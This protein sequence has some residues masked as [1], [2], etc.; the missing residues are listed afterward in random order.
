MI[1][2]N[3]TKKQL[4]LTSKCVDYYSSKQFKLHQQYID[5]NGYLMNEYFALDYKTKNW[6]KRHNKKRHYV[7]NIISRKKIKNVQKKK[8]YFKRKKSKISNVS[9]IQRYNNRYLLQLQF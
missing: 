3:C 5:Y 6:S 2:Y 9:S 1:C 8:S 4:H 7:G